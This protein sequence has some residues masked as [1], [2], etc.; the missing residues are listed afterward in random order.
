MGNTIIFGLIGLAVLL[1]IICTVVW[2]SGKKKLAA[3]T[4]EMASLDSDKKELLNRIAVLEEKC[5]RITPLEQ[6]LAGSKS[7]Q[8]KLQAEVVKLSTDLATEVEKNQH[9]QLKYKEM[10]EKLN[11]AS[12]ELAEA[13]EKNKQMENLPAELSKKEAAIEELQATVNQSKEKIADLDSQ[14]DEERKKAEEQS[15]TIDKLKKL[16]V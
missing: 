15:N 12:K 6:D 14:L 4:A 11:S 2:L 5:N 8:E 1:L 16:F 13:L 3:L 9:S 7:K 10:Q